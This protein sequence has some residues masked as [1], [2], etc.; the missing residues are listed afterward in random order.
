MKEM[1]NNWVF[2]ILFYLFI[3]LFQLSYFERNGRRF[4][5]NS[6]NLFHKNPTK[7]VEIRIE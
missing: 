2:I 6:H 5:Y 1:H 4:L 3:Y 7:S